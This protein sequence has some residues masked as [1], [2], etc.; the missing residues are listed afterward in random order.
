MRDRY[1]E[2]VKEWRDRFKEVTNEWKER[3]K[4]WKDPAK[5]SIHEGCL[6]PLPLPTTPSTSRTRHNV[7]ASHIGDE[8]MHVIDMLI[9]AGLFST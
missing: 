6:P 2:A 8:E 4:N 9:E 1:R 3:M 5:S 7:V